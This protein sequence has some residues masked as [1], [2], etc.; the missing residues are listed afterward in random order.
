MSQSPA[1]WS[2]VVEASEAKGHPLFA[3]IQHAGPWQYQQHPDGGTVATWLGEVFDPSAYAVPRQVFESLC[4][5]APKQMVHIHDLV[6]PGNPGAD[7]TLA[8]G[9]TLTIPVA[10]V[11]HRQMRLG[12]GNV[13]LGD[14][15]TE[16]GR[17]ACRMLEEAK[18]DGGV[19]NDSPDLLRLI[20]LAIGQRYRVTSEMLDDMAIISADDI[21]P[22][23]ACAWMGDPKALAPASAGEFNASPSCVSTGAK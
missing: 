3:S 5:L 17:L 2:P 22:I 10:T 21:D 4:Y 7:V 18:R 13:G 11:A 6:L 14:P 8:C 23:L 15:V 1:Y 9:I 16:Y 19:P 12:R 20:E